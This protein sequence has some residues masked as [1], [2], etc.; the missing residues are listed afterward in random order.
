MPAGGIR[1][2]GLGAK[3]ARQTFCTI[4]VH[5][6][7]H[8]FDV[9]PPRNPLRSG[10]TGSRLPTSWVSRVFVS[11]VLRPSFPIIFLILMP[12]ERALSCSPFFFLHEF[13]NELF[14]YCIPVRGLHSGPGTQVFLRPPPR[15]S[16]DFLATLNFFPPFFLSKQY[17]LPSKGAIRSSHFLPPF[18]LAFSLSERPPPFRPFLLFVF[19]R[20]AAISPLVFITRPGY[21]CCRCF[22]VVFP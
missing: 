21:F 1:L 5:C 13:Y 11:P 17:T 2:V 9:P 16:W 18:L 8:L 22:S 12:S 20:L 14:S 3:F 19:F 4:S 10:K 15:P 6:I 7:C